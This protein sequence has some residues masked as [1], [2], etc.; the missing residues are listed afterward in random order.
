ME[1]PRQFDTFILRDRENDVGLRLMCTGFPD[2]TSDFLHDL[3]QYVLFLE[4]QLK[5]PSSQ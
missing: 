2:M 1:R 5:K 4:T 3:M